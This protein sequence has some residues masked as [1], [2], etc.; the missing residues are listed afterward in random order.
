MDAVQ[1]TALLREYAFSEA[2]FERVRALVHAQIGISLSASKRALVYGRL[3]R[4]LRA[5][6]LPDFNSYLELLSHDDGLELQHFH[7]AITTNLTSFFRE[8]HHFDYLRAQLLPALEQQNAATRRIRIW[9]AGCSSGEEPY[10]IAMVLRETLGHLRNWDVR[11]LATDV[12]TNVLDYAR[13]G[14]Y[15]GDRME[16]MDG[17]RLQRWFTRAPDGEH[18]QAAA[19]LQALISFKPLN[20]VQPWPMRGIFDAIFCR[21]VVIYFDRDTQ[22]D[23]FGRMAALQRSGDHLFLGHSES[24]LNVST[25]YQLAGQTIH[26]KAQ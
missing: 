15:S 10:S 11:V 24:L 8:H 9:S 14:Q 6:Q 18:Y 20:L 2:D 25:Q 19:E 21:N 1:D 26:R 23:V 7:N 13:R 22:R 5:L 3:S 4:R 17:A 16:K 12:D